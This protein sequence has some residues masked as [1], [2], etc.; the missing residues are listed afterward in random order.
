V[1]TAFVFVE[2]FPLNTNGKVDRRALAALRPEEEETT[3]F[4]AP[5]TETE[6]RLAAVWSDLLG[7]A[8]DR[9]V[10]AGDSF[11]DLGGHSLLGTRLV[12]R[13]R[14]AL[15]VELP[16]RALFEAPVLADLAARV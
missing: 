14:A 3:A 15:G 9:R 12:S 6:R 4:V 7:L 13:I 2:S 5:R 16:L 10:G 11:F 1:P 8:P